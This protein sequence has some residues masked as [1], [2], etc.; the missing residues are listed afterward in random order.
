M[1]YLS[2]VSPWWSLDRQRQVLAERLTGAIVFVDELDRRERRAHQVASLV[3]RAQMLRPTARKGRGE[4]IHVASLAVLAWSA[5]DLLEVLNT[6]AARGATLVS[7]TDQEVS[8]AAWREARD[9]ARH[10][11]LQ[12]AG[13]AVSA[14]KR[15]ADTDAAIAEHVKPFWHLPSA[16]HPTAALIERA[17]LTLNTIKSRLGPRQIAQFQHRQRLARRKK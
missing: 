8:V 9:R 11:R 3:Q 10:E 4:A 5:E 17:G 16:D 13:A 7:A 2:E 1:A 14:A 15:R 6:I 12:V